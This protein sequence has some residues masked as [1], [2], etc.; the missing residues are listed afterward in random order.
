MYPYIHIL[1]THSYYTILSYYTIYYIILT[2][3]LLGY[4]REFADRPLI[5]T[6]HGQHANATDPAVAKAYRITN[7]TVR[8]RLLVMA[9]PQ[10]PRTR[11]GGSEPARVRLR[12]CGTHA[13]HQQQQSEGQ[14][15]LFSVSKEEVIVITGN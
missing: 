4:A 1:Y 3:G 14:A 8:L 2:R 15:V 6:W 13:S 10:S 9:G 7:E 12:L 5:M 11:R